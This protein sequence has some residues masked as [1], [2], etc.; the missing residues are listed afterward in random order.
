MHEMHSCDRVPEQYKRET[1]H[2]KAVLESM[3]GHDSSHAD[4]FER[5]ER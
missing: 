1:M 5:L 4:K 3:L 2:M